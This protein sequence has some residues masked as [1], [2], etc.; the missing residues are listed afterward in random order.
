MDKPLPINLSAEQ[1]VLG[2]ILIDEE[3]IVAVSPI[4]KTA[5]F[6]QDKH[7]I[8]YTSMLS[9]YNR[10]EG[11][12]E[13]TL[14]QEINSQKKLEEVGVDYFSQ[15]ISIT[16]TSIHAEYYAKIVKST[17]IRRRLISAGEQITSLAQE[18][19]DPNKCMSKIDQMLMSIQSDMAQPHLIT[20][21]QLSEIG[22]TH[23]GALRNPQ[24]RVS[25]ST[26]FEELDYHTGGL[27]PGDFVV[28]AARAG[29]GKSQV[30]LQMAQCAGK[31]V[32]VLFCPIEMHFKQI[33]DRMVSSETGIPIR[34]IRSGGYTD[35]MSDRIF[36]QAL[37]SVFESGIYMMALNNDIADT[38]QI[39]STLI[40][41]MARHMKSAYGLGLIVVDYIGLLDPI[42]G[43]EKRQR[44]E[45]VRHISRRLKVMANSLE[46][47]LL[48]VAQINR[49]PERRADKRPSM[50]D[51]S[52]S[53]GLEQDA[54]SIY[55]LYRDDYYDT[56]ANNKG[57]AE[58]CLAKQ[59]QGKAN[60]VLP[61]H[62]DET[63]SRYLEI[64]E[65]PKVNRPPRETPEE[66]K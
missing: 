63:F 59:R 6:F 62:W 27:F 32:P 21:E 60:I 55:L 18:E 58:F 2:S 20:P 35:E 14:A 29:L 41:T 54:D 28:L 16:P 46:V 33:L 49:E 66:F 7:Q 38:P 39:T 23:Y 31:I 56:E 47:P 36:S 30:A 22:A 50:S 4:L 64:G 51:L 3:A 61:L 48:A 5:D 15:L 53:G 1:S 10:G 34:Q 37:P 19:T 65:P 24:H 12:N 13:I 11:I 8:I 26:G 45:Q 40:G 44:S 43:D 17:S 42:A 52:E 57:E 9:L 25:I